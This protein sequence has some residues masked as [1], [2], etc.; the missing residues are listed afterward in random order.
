MKNSVFSPI[1][2]IALRRFSKKPDENAIQKPLYPLHDAVRAGNL[3]RVKHILRTEIVP[4]NSLND[5][6]ELP[7]GIAA[8]KHNQDK[9]YPGEILR[10]LYDFG[11]CYLYENRRG[12]SPARNLPAQERKDNQ[13]MPST[14]WHIV[15]DSVQHMLDGCG[16][17]LKGCTNRCK[18]ETKS[19]DADFKAKVALESITTP[20]STG[21]LAKKHRVAEWEVIKWRYQ[22]REGLV[23][24][25]K[26]PED[27]DKHQAGIRLIV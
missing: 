7:L 9:D 24:L 2:G 16:L 13:P 22:A 27:A 17:P 21:E 8:Q 1:S 6:D 26:D 11:A 5:A 23:N 18:K 3:Q 25:F 12:E 14:K 15:L 10:E 4:V 19:Y 20:L